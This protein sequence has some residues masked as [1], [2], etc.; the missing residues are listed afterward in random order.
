MSKKKSKEMFG[1]LSSSGVCEALK[2]LHSLGFAH[3]DVRLPNVFHYQW[4]VRLIDFDRR[5]PS[6]CYPPMEYVGSFMY[7]GEPAGRTTVE[8]LDWKQ[9]GIMIY[10]I[11]YPH[12]TEAYVKEDDVTTVDDGFLHS[13]IF[14]YTYNDALFE[15][16]KNEL[17]TEKEFETLQDVTHFK[18]INYIHIDSVAGCIITLTVPMISWYIILLFKNCIKLTSELILFC[19]LY[20]SSFCCDVF[21]DLQ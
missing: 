11:M 12:E 19:S 10:C 16:W 20:L 17:E 9:L 18:I 2:Q 8:Q 5:L 14:N 6:N 15:Q 3:L 1:Q 21:V 13:L 7:T 4:D